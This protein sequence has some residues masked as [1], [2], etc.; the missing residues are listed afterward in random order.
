MERR[1][2]E[3]RFQGKRG[4]G[5]TDV[6][7]SVLWEKVFDD[8]HEQTLRITG[9]GASDSRSGGSISIGSG[10]ISSSSG[11]SSSS[12]S[13]ADSSSSASASAPQRRS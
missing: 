9:S 5:R 3:V 4:I 7:A 8:A 1:N 6:V 11:V 13:S 10:N 2:G 12:S